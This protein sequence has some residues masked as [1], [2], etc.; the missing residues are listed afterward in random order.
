[1][2]KRQANSVSLGAGDCSPRPLCHFHFQ[3]G[4]GARTLPPLALPSKLEASHPQGALSP[5]RP[6]PT[7]CIFQPI[8]PSP[9]PFSPHNPGSLWRT[10]CN[11]GSEEED[12]EKGEG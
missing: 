2:G 9:F 7:T 4:G 5:P 1:M 11:T 6:H 10:L 3:A 12:R 8:T